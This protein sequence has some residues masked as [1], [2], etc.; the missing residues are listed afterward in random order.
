MPQTILI[1]GNVG[2][3]AVAL[4]AGLT[5]RE[6]VYA[7]GGFTNLPAHVGGNEL[8]IFDSVG[9]VPLISPER[10]VEIAGPQTI[11]G[12][13]TFHVRTVDPSLRITGGTP[14]HV[15]MSL[16]ATTGELEWGEAAAGGPTYTFGTGLTLTGTT[17]DLDVAG[18]APADLGGVYVPAAL[19][20]AGLDID[21]IK[22]D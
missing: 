19:T 14:G 10:Q 15:L 2:T 4:P 12:L 18:R 9:T 17:V 1:K 3:G 11:T 7:R 13:K 22:V 5:E 20:G 6:L 21:N 16:N 8:A